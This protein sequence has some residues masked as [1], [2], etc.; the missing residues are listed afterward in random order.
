[1]AKDVYIGFRTTAEIRKTLQEMANEGFRTLSQQC[2]MVV[3]QWLKQ[4]DQLPD[5]PKKKP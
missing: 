1:M 5:K 2:E 3:I 4:H